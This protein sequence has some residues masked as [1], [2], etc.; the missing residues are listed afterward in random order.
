MKK[1]LALLLACITL[2]CLLN[3][4]NS[5][6][7]GT[8]PA[9][10]SAQNEQPAAPSDAV[11]P[12][13]EP[14][15]T[16]RIITDMAG[17]EVTIPSDIKSVYCAVPTAEAMI[18]SLC[19][20]K[21]VGWV[22][23][24]SDTM[25][26]YL[27]EKFATLPVISGW[28]GQK[29]T[30]NMEDIAQLN[31]DAVIYMTNKAYLEKDETPTQI[32][33]QTGRPVIVVLSDFQYTAEVYRFLGGCLGENDR[34]EKLATYCEE[35]MSEISD[36]MSKVPESDKLSIYYAE[37]AD[38]LSTDPSGSGH[39]EVLDF[40]GVKN[41]A[42]VE[43][44]GGMGMTAVTIEQVIN[45]N[46]DVILVSA[47]TA[48]TYQQVNTNAIWQNIKA[49]QDGKIYYTPSLPFNWF[50]RPPNIMRVLG[51]QW[52]ASVIYPDYVN[53]DIN[54]E[55]KE[56]FNTFYNVQLTDDQVTSLVAA[57]SIG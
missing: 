57:P 8:A 13:D 1:A 54:T 39:T 17:R 53:Y 29:V 45:W 18:S 19:P 9:S 26:Q 2:L 51:I 22:N 33:K 31:P 30:A 10:D 12:S 6:D 34:G 37:G 36:A 38:G 5:Q 24:P 28:M 56:F 41:I 25:L 52:F 16:T 48:D 23:K 49:V 46:P 27:P 43:A 21:L 11:S 35:K 55:I 40:V 20:D 3:G 15:D 47:S 7:S 32:E 14:Q 50:D 42:E 4:C 44:L